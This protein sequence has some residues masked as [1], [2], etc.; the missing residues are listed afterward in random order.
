MKYFDKFGTFCNNNAPARIRNQHSEYLTAH[1]LHGFTDGRLG[2]DS[3][4]LAVNDLSDCVLA[5]LEFAM[6]ELD[7]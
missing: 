7:E 6:S 5:N 3:D 1:F 2:A 4:W